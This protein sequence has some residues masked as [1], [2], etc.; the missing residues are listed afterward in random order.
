MYNKH[1]PCLKSC[2]F[3]NSGEISV[4]TPSLAV[5]ALKNIKPVQQY[6]RLK[7]VTMVSENLY[8]HYP[9]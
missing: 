3:V 8:S 5:R 6:G 2:A 7:T 4:L 9:S 1:L